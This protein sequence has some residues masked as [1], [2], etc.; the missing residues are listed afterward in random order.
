MR[1]PQQTGCAACPLR[2]IEDCNKQLFCSH[3]LCS[4]GQQFASVS[5]QERRIN[6]QREHHSSHPRRLTMA[7][8][9][10]MS[11]CL[12]THVPRKLAIVPALGAMSSKGSSAFQPICG[13]RQADGRKQPG[14][15]HKQP[16][17]VV[18]WPM[19]ARMRDGRLAIR[20]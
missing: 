13:Q 7:E 17:L 4:C 6:K 19:S 12:C 15:Y 9:K 16:R 8:S 5:S 11:A 20:R 2:S 14:T 1:C 3:R 10:S 18:P